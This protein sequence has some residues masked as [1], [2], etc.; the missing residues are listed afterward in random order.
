MREDHTI[1]NSAKIHTHPEKLILYRHMRENS[2]M[3]KVQ[4]L[5][6]AVNQETVPSATRESLFFEICADLLKEAEKHHWEDNLWHH[7][8]TLL[9]VQAENPF[10]RA[11]AWGR[12][13]NI[14]S[15]LVH[16]AVH[17]VGLLKELFDLDFRL[18]GSWVPSDIVD[19]LEYY[20]RG[21]SS[22]G[23][24]GNGPYA[25]RVAALTRSFPLAPPEELVQDL[26]GFYGAFGCGEMGWFASFRWDPD[27]GL[28]G[29]PYPDPVRL[30]DLIGYQQQKTVIIHNTEAFIKGN[31]ANNILL[32]GERGTG[33]SST[34]KALVNAYYPEG[35]RL[36]EVDKAQ[37]PHFLKIMRCVRAYPQRFLVFIDDLS[38]ERNE[39]EYKY[40]KYILE[41]GME[42]LPDNVVIYAT[43]NR[44]H[45]VQ[46]TW[47][48]RE[49]GDE[50][51]AADALAEKLSLSDRFGL[52]VTF[53]SPDQEK[54]LEIVAGLAEKNGITLPL[55]ELRERALHWERWHNGRSG[56]TAKQFINSLLAEQ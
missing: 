49:G 2:L 50:V 55:A 54:Y 20:P 47:D 3:K 24:S 36:L 7:Y 18:L 39:T 30:D 8:L 19:V 5:M 16:L 13:K 21:F 25:E 22:P 51:R 45:L 43:S 38:F 28:V 26:M 35:L 1:T 17:D 41:G 23:P 42:T 15:G 40:L 56:R 44:R 10:S 52:T 34:I 48:E 37:F 32:Y 53:T 6:G 31:R 12:G 33:K 9:I 11:S 46:E 29:I 14:G 4:N 27:Q